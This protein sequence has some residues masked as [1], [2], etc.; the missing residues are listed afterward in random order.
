MIIIYRIFKMSFAAT[1]M[2]LERVIL[3]EI[4]R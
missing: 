4:E 3:N 2:G 1:W